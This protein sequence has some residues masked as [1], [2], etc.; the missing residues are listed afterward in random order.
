[1]N[2]KY[3]IFIL[4]FSAALISCGGAP[5]PN[6]INCSPSGMEKVLP[7]FSSEAERQAFIDKCKSGEEK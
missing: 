7:T 3:I 1:M 4:G 5:E 6:S 2:S